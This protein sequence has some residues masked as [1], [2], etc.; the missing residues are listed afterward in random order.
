MFKRMNVSVVS[1]GAPNGFQS[2]AI[3]GFD[4]IY[5]SA[6]ELWPSQQVLILADKHLLLTITQYYL[7]LEYVIYLIVL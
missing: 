6:C 3:H 5:Q 1:I 7:N 4:I 2:A